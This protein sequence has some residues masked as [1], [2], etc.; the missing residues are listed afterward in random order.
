VAVS[1]P[2]GLLERESELRRLGTLLDNAREGRGGVALVE[3]PAGIGKTRLLE[4][5]REDAVGCGLRV[6]TARG[7]DLERQFSYGVVRQLFEAVVVGPES[8]SPARRLGGAATF[9]EPVFGSTRFA[10]AEGEPPDRS[11]AVRHGLHQLTCDLAASSPLLFEV[12]DAHWADAPSLLFLHYLA[13]RV[14]ELPVAVVLSSRSGQRGPESDLVRR[15]AAEASASVLELEPLSLEATTELVRALLGA[16]SAA[17]LCRACHAATGGNPFLVHELA[18]A[19]GAE[20]LPPDAE[21][22]GR[23]GRLVPDAVA[24]H[25]LVRLSRLGGVA[26]RVARAVAVLG[27]GAGLRHVA[28]LA[29]LSEL[30][31]ADAVDALVTADILSP[32]LPLAFAHPLLG[33]AVYADTGPGERTLAHDRAARMLADAGSPPERVALQ[34]LAC[35]P[36]GSEWAVATLRAAARE[37]SDRGAPGPAACYL[38]RALAEP[39]VPEDRR[40]LLLQLGVAES[41]S[42]QPSAAD[43]LSEALRLTERPIARGRIAQELAGLYNLLGRFGESAAVLE[44]AI[45][46]LGEA[47]QELRFS[48]EAEAAV[49][50]VTTLEGRQELGPKLA[51]FRA[52]AAAMINAPAA[53][54]LLAVVAHELTTTDGTACEAAAHAE[55][56]FADARLF[57][58]EGAVPSIGAA[59]LVTV[60]SPTK[61]E[62]I[63]DHLIVAAQSRGSLPAMCQALVNRAYARN[64][65]GRLREA[66]ADARLS[67]ELSASEPSD[68]VRPHKIGQLAEALFEQARTEE[69]E[70]LLAGSDLG[71]PECDVLAQQLGE[72]HARLLLLQGRRD[73]AWGLL[74][75]HLRWQ[76]MWGCQNPGWTSIRS[77]AA[78]VRST[79]NK[80]KEAHALAAEELDAACA[81]GAPRAVGIALRTMA[82]VEAGLRLSRL[83]E[84]VAVLEGSEARL[85]LARSLTELG[86]ALRRAGRRREARQPLRRGFELAHGCGGTLVADRARTE[87]LAT[88]ARPRRPQATG[89]DALTASERRVAAMATEGLSNREIAQG[90]FLSSK[91]VEMHLSHVY[92]KL[93]IHS[94]TQ[95]AGALGRGETT[96]H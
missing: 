20:G 7:G 5:A 78:L 76:Q 45:D 43:H 35:E 68:P 57:S 29:G 6:L 62:A 55:R 85:E 95:L 2:P 14:D 81:F 42:A 21:A 8:A 31:T 40:E 19:L 49:L 17:E 65:R 84:S 51:A 44:E 71:R 23:V 74:E 83:R 32:G 61:A 82:L 93:G 34:L 90:L 66:E 36:T 38:Q 22:A 3:G 41:R 26:I 15:I 60:D 63:L 70:R 50:G 80:P 39:P 24:R 86:S 53:A 30:E 56:A 52:K 73:E 46:A 89:R 67:L 69:V 9:A 79:L 12:D 75:A 88:G 10:A 91:T 25:V 16:D 92:R 37:A 18:T 48:L 54:P 47:D 27:A 96:G 1:V 77:T 87:L 28:A 72:L 13:R 64:R 4:A 33:E 11:A 58:R 59:A 94:R